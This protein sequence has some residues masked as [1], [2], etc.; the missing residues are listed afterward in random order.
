MHHGVIEVRGC[1]R[2]DR[3]DD[4]ADVDNQV[5]VVGLRVSPMRISELKGIQ[6]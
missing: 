5:V 4:L 2:Q 1:R 6:Y 3:R